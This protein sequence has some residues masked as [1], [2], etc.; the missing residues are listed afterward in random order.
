MKNHYEVIG[1]S[2]KVYSN[3]KNKHL[4][5]FIDVADLKLIASYSWRVYVDNKKGYMRVETS[6]T[7]NNKTTHFMLA[8][9]LMNFPKG[10]F[11]DHKDCDSL[12]NR[13][14]NLRLATQKE[15]SRNAPKTIRKTHSKFRGVSWHKRKNKWIATCAI[16]TKNKFLG[17]FSTEIDAAKAYDKT[18]KELHGEFA[19]TNFL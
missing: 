9:F 15:N 6:V 18:A 19:K 14:S 16:N 7:E 4:Y 10:K 13:R 5:F 3:G 2:V 11:S 1:D 17:Y 8:R 12:N